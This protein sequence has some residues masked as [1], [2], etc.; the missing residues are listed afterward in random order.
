GP[1][2]HGLHC[3]QFSIFQGGVMVSQLDK[4]VFGFIVVVGSA[5][6]RVGKGAYDKPI[7]F[8]IAVNDGHFESSELAGQ[9]VI[10]LFG[11]VVEKMSLPLRGDVGSIRH[12]PTVVLVSGGLQID[13]VV[14]IE[15][16]Y[17]FRIGYIV[18][19]QRKLV[20]SYV[21][22]RKYAVLA[23][24][25]ETD[26]P[27]GRLEVIAGDGPE[28]VIL[29]RPV[30]DGFACAIACQ[31]QPQLALRVGKPANDVA[32]VTS[33]QGTQLPRDIDTVHVKHPVL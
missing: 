21:R 32:G 24:L 20:A 19:Y 7:A 18:F 22:Q 12:K 2:G 10:H 26:G 5:G 31:G 6:V 30:E 29:R 11:L 23:S 1:E 25:Q 15:H 17:F 16:P 13:V 28:R 14:A 33:Y 8:V 4:L 9:A 3:R 27:D